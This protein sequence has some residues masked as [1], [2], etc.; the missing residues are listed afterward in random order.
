MEIKI[1]AFG[2][3]VTVIPKLFLY[4]T[5]NAYGTPTVSLGIQLYSE[6]GPFA[7]LTTSFGEFIG[8]KNA[9]YVDTNNCQLFI[10]QLLPLGFAKDTG[11]RKTSGYCS[12]PLWL[13]TPKFLKECGEEEYQKYLNC[14]K[15]VVEDKLG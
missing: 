15:T 7:T 10:D 9:A 12:Y 5:A 14:Y 13:F 3:N 2:R 4:K 1:N 11:L 6:N 8:I